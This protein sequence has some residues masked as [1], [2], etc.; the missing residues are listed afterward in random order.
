M[1]AFKLVLQ[2]VLGISGLIV[3][4]GVPLFIFQFKLFR[5]DMRELKHDVVAIGNKLDV[6]ISNYDIHKVD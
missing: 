1:E 2:V 6:H 5:D 4:A 3:S